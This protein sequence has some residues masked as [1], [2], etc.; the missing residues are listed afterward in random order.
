MA[1]EMCNA[2][3]DKGVDFELLDL[4]D[5]NIPFCDGDECY[6]HETTILLRKK[7]EEA[8]GILMAIPVYNF[9]VSSSAKN[10]VELTGKMWE[11]KIA[12]FMSAASGKNG[13]MSVMGLANSLMLDFR[14]VIIPRHVYAEQVAFK[15]GKIDKEIK[16]RIDELGKNMIRFSNAL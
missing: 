13:Y 4:R 15:N 8:K 5:Y 12:G 2:L 1:R 16:K 7:V 3:E 14:V 11:G 9:N 10:F 6:D